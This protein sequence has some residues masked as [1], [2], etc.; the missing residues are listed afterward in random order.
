MKVCLEKKKK[1]K[2]GI[3]LSLRSIKN[4]KSSPE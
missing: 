4:D 1:A 2:D 3:L